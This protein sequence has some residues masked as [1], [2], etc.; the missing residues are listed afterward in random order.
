MTWEQI[1][2]AV[3]EIEAANAERRIVRVFAPGAAPDLFHGKFGSAPIEAR[4]TPG[5][6]W[7]DGE[8]IDL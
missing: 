2:A 7:N 4:E 8:I 1:N 5:Y 6:Q 3:T